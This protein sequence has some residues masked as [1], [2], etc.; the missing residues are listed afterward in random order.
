MG[1]ICLDS[2]L[3]QGPIQFK[4]VSKLSFSIKGN[5]HG[6]LVV[7]GFLDEDSG[8]SAVYKDLEGQPFGIYS[9]MVGVIPIFIGVIKRL[10]VHQ[11]NR[12]YLAEAH[13]VT[14]SA[15]LDEK[16]KAVLSKILI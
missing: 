8:S 11:I 6:H 9:T 16:K 14:L 5:E 3:L 4:S 15:K 12:Q 1:T 7:T 13:V 2:L 10:F